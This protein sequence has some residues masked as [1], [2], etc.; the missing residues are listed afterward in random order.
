MTTS[1]RGP[2]DPWAA[3]IESGLAL[4]CTCQRDPVMATGERVLDAVFAGNH[5][6]QDKLGGRLLSCIQAVIDPDDDYEVNQLVRVL[7]ARSLLPVHGLRDWLL[8]SANPEV[9]EIARTL[10]A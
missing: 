5:G 7:R 2:R 4:A 6:L 8:D 1:E 3:L 9:V 10:P